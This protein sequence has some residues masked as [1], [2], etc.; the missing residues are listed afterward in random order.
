LDFDTVA[1]SFLFDK[2]YLEQLGLKYSSRDLQINCVI[3]YLFLSIFNVPCICRK[4][5]C[6]GKSCK[7]LGFW[8]YLN[9]ASL[10]LPPLLLRL[11]GG[12]SGGAPRQPQAREASS[13]L[14]IVRLA[15][16][17]RWPIPPA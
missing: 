9:E 2:H 7:I 11:N 8:V 1:F 4:I 3:S 13:S 14:R 15:P 16:A 5:R 17:A 12:K 10:L 6:D